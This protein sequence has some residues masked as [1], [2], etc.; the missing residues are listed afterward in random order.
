MKRDK[1]QSDYSSIKIILFLKTIT[2]S[3]VSAFGVI[4]VS[5]SL[6]SD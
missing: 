3:K 2:A 1:R 5:I 4:K 6:H